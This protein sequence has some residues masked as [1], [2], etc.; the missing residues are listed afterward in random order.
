MEQF[1]CME[2]CESK[3]G[4]GGSVGMTV[5]WVGDPSI[6]EWRAN[7]Y[8][9]ILRELLDGWTEDV[10]SVDF[11]PQRVAGCDPDALSPVAVAQAAALPSG[12][13][14]LEPSVIFSDETFTLLYHPESVEEP[15]PID[16]LGIFTD[17]LL[18]PWIVPSRSVTGSRWAT[19]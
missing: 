5:E 18:W 1:G 2:P 14:Q 16:S 15:G 17:L 12:E 13:S 3:V 19:G 4:G 7:W 10:T 8:A 9:P 6:E 11:A